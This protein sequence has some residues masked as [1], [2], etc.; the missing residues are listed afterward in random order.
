VHKI[1]ISDLNY[2][3]YCWPETDDEE[4]D[5]EDDDEEVD[6]DNEGDE[7]EEEI[8]DDDDDVGSCGA[9]GSEAEWV[10]EDEDEEEPPGKSANK[11]SKKKKKPKAK[12]RSSTTVDVRDA[13]CGTKT[14]KCNKPLEKSPGWPIFLTKEGG[15]NM[16]RL[17]DEN[18][19][20]NQANFNMHIYNDWSG[21][22]TAEVLTNAVRAVARRD[23]DSFTD[24]E[25]ARQFQQDHLR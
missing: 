12:K 23:E 11:S 24:R 6:N 7:E 1:E 14:C 5:E 9:E 19:R 2:L 25:K 4:G 10:T 15:K 21:W 16:F 22:G 20:R 17:I 8:D 3:T 13:K 18:E